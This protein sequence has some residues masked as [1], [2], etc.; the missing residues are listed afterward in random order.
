MGD[1]RAASQRLAPAEFLFDALTDP[2]QRRRTFV[3]VLLGF[4][5]VWTLY[6]VLAHGGADV[7]P[8]VSQVV[9]WSRELTLQQICPVLQ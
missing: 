3:V 8:D 9:L 2:P 7:H 4:L 6:G 1:E 5:A